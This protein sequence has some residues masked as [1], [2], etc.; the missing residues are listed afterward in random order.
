M[1][2]LSNDSPTR[3]YYKDDELNRLFAEIPERFQPHFTTL[4][5]T[6][7]R[8]GEIMLLEWEDIH[9]E[10]GYIYIKPHEG[11]TR[12]KMKPRII[13]IHAEVMKAFEI[14]KQAKESKKIVFSA[15]EGKVLTHNVLYEVL[16]MAKKS[17]NVQS[18]CL[19]S[20]RHTFASKLINKGISIKVVQ[21]LLGHEDIKT[22]EIYSH[23]DIKQFKHILSLALDFKIAA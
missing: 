2:M 12:R 5:Y 6:G 1:E 21:E 16:R 7:I 4:L 18:G 20:F 3:H 15:R 8:K 13:P 9:F 19:H 11:R 22:T 10:E 23:I 14:R 17:A